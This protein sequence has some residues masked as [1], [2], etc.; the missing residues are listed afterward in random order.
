ME[1]Q[2]RTLLLVWVA[3]VVALVV[4]LAAMGA[5]TAVVVA[6]TT[7]P[8]RRLDARPAGWRHGSAAERRDG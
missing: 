5:P 1:R 2:S 4:T 6:R 8:L 3:A 7:C